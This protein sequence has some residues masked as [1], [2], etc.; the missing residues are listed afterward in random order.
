MNYVL[1]VF[2]SITTANKIKNMLE[3]KLK[4]KS[5]VMQTPKSVPIK[6]CSYCLRVSE[7]DLPSVWRLVKSADVY[8]KGVFRESDYSKI[9]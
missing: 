2:A 1:I 7:E 5:K 3:K 9:L 8:T 6:S 4:I